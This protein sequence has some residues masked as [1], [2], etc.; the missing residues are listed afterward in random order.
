MLSTLVDY[1]FQ[2]GQVDIP[3]VGRLQCIRQPA[4]LDVAD[5]VIHA[6]T[7]HV[8]LLE[9]GEVTQHQL[10]TTGVAAHLL[11][12]FGQSLKTAVG[13]APLDWP[14]LGQ[15]RMQQGAVFF[16]AFPPSVDALHP[17]PAQRV[18]HEGAEH[19]VLVGDRER[20]NV[21][22]KE[23]LSRPDKRR[24]PAMIIAWVLLALMVLGIAAWLYLGGFSP[25][26]AGTRWPIGN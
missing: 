21:Q 15:F 26:A 11:Q 1:L 19:S 7:T 8:E 14:G 3:G 10:E 13:K 9:E 2:Y 4:R 6:P 12:Q 22:M 5:H 17:V 25:A 18:I 24:S 23:A 16:E 20:T